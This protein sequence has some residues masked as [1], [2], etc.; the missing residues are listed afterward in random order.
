MLKYVLLVILLILAVISCGRTYPVLDNT[1]VQ[2]KIDLEVKLF[3]DH[4]TLN[5]Y[6]EETFNPSHSYEVDGLASWFTNDPTNKC[7][8]HV[9]RPNIANYDAERILGHE[10]LH[11]MYGNYHKEP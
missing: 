9:V 5:R 10:L 4:N 2:T 8:I 7:T 1:K 6:I 11:C 3:K